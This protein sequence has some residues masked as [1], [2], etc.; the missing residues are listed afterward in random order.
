MRIECRRKLLSEQ[1]MREHEQRTA[2][3][4]PNP[5]TSLRNAFE[6]CGRQPPDVCAVQLLL[7]RVTE[8]FG[9]LRLAQRRRRQE[10]DRE[11]RDKSRDGSSESDLSRRGS[12]ASIRRVSVP[13]VH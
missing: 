4:A 3:A 12:Y 5:T 13:L 10:E 8:R 1:V 6:T 2:A 11:Q 9:L 7:H